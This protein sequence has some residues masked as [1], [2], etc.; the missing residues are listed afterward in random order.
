MLCF[1]HLIHGHSMYKLLRNDLL[2]IS[3]SDRSV[4]INSKNLG[5]FFERYPPCLQTQHS[6][7]T[8]QLRRWRI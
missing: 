4:T 3:G 1:N 5:S 8:L 2:E 7:I 6:F